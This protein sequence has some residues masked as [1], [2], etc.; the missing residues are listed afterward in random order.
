MTKLKDVQ[1]KFEAT[2]QI[3]I[4]KKEIDLKAKNGVKQLDKNAAL[5]Q[6]K[7]VLQEGVENNISTT[8]EDFITMPVS[9]VIKLDQLFYVNKYLQKKWLELPWFEFYYI[10]IFW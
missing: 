7:T 1:L 9:G 4:F 2:A 3:R 5:T 6:L 10:W 8:E